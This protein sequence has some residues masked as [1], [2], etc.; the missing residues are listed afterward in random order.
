MFVFKRAKP[1]TSSTED[2]NVLFY[3][4]EIES[5]PS[6]ARIDDLHRMWRGDFERLEMHHGY[7]QWLFPVFENAGMNWE[8]EPLSKAG[9][10]LIRNDPTMSARVIESYKLM[11]HFYG[12]VLTDELTGQVERDPNGEHAR[13]RLTNLNYSSHNWLR[14]SRILTSLGELGFRRYKAPLLEALRKEVA[15]GYVQ[16]AAGSFSNFWR[17]VVDEEDSTWYAQKTLELAEDRAEGCLFAPGGRLAAP[18]AATATAEA[19]EAAS[20]VASTAAAEA[21]SEDVSE[22]SA[23]PAADDEPGGETS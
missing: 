12:L 15:S 7:I 20:T 19:A 16:K 5:R 9:A 14:V 23:T 2:P 22:T 17:R 4:G 1:S 8:S 10:A 6:G 3:R 13:E 21:T 18:P 11:L